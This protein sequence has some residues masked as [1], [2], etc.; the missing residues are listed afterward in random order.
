VNWDDFVFTDQLSEK[1]GNIYDSE[2]TPPD[3]NKKVV[4]DFAAGGI[5]QYANEKGN[6]YGNVGF[7]VD[8]VFQP[9]QSFLSTGASPLP[10][11]WIVHTDAVISIGET[12]SS[13]SVSRGAEE[14]L[15]INPGVLFVSQG[16]L[17]S[18][19]LGFNLMKFNIFLGTWY[20]STLTGTTSNSMAVLAG[21]RFYF[22]EKMSIK[23]LYSYDI[24]ISGALIGTGGAHEISLVL[25]FEEL[26]MF[27]G[28]SKAF[29]GGRTK[30]G[31]EPLDCPVLY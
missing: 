4:P 28:R 6:L 24:P 20:K 16:K 31:Y 15:K 7:A 29:M 12:S 10:R 26:Q 22:A 11:K 30:R 23:F 19:E 13:S 25:D 14:P 21:Y 17:N 5:L 18:I 8:H 3:A 27:G 2:F 1:Y 9:D